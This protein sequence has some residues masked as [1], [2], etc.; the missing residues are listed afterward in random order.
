MY[1]FTPEDVNTTETRSKKTIEIQVS[2]A[3]FHCIY[4]RLKVV[5]RPKHV[6]DNLNKI[7]KI[8]ETELR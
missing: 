1:F 2:H 7:L 8:I 4:F 3:N 5:V 6:T